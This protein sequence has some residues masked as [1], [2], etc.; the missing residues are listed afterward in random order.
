M[1]CDSRVSER[2]LREIYLRPFE[3]CVREGSPW[4]IMTAYNFINGKRCCESNELL[5]NILRK[6]WGYQGAVT[7]DWDVPCDQSECVL[8]GNDIRMPAGFPERLREALNEGKLD[9]NHLVYCVK[10]T[11]GLILKLD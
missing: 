4:L 8:A 3:L 11:L 2:A 7:S 1:H 5:E 9:R 10:H 6:E